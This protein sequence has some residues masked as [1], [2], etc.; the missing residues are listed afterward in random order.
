MV[1]FKDIIKESSHLRYVADNLAFCTSMGRE[2][3]L[4]STLIKSRDTLEKEYE[5]MEAMKDKNI[6]EI[7]NILT[8]LRDIRTTISHLAHKQTL[9]EIELF[10]V[11]YFSF[12]LTKLNK[13]IEIDSLNE[14]FTILDPN[15][16][17]VVNFYIYDIYDET[18]AK[19]RK[20]EKSDDILVSISLQEDIVRVKLSEQLF[21][22]AER[23]KSAIEHVADIDLVIAKNNFIKNNNLVRPIITD[24]YSK[25]TYKEIFNP[26]LLSLI[27]NY[28]KIDVDLI[29]SPTLI[30]GANMSGKTMLLKTIALAQYMV[31]FG[32]YAPARYAE[33]TLV[34]EIFL[35]VGDSQREEE[36]LS[37][38]AAEILNVSKIIDTVEGKGRFLVLLDELART[39][40]P[41]EGAAIVDGVTTLL[42]E[43]GVMSLITT[44]YS[45]L[46]ADVRC[47][48][49][50]GFTESKID[51]TVTKENIS[52][53]IDY[54]LVD[55]TN[56]EHQN[57]E[58]IRIAKILGV[59]KKL[60]DIIENVQR[61]QIRY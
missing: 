21:G 7:R 42:K 48:R 28:Q 34:D 25:T 55:V 20:M 33:V 23:L 46:T 47:K 9:N 19:L 26:Y 38:Y 1:K 27:K 14:I 6:A 35:S 39:T 24:T 57:S 11:K 30:T 58:A 51:K 18:L 61:K 2:R 50:K 41:H 10:E 13:F 40:S 4:N 44:H 29:T 52:Q 17:G 22:F 16:S 43:K 60:I 31:Q 5:K 32:F 37:S 56:N 59:N 53:Y 3:L 12:H 54:S 45:V 49:V 8:Q 15:K 36:G